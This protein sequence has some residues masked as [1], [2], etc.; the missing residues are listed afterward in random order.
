VSQEKM[1]EFEQV[2]VHGMV[3]LKIERNKGKKLSVIDLARYIPLHELFY[4]KEEFRTSKRVVTK[5]NWNM[6]PV[7]IKLLDVKHN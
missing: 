6:M 3:E 7:A 2:L 5:A 4:E 1:K